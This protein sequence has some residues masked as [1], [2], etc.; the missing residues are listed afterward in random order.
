MY[1][2]KNVKY[3]EYAMH[4]F[5]YGINIVN[6]P[7]IYNYNRVSGVLEMQKIPNMSIADY[8]GE[9]FSAV[10]VHIITKIRE[11]IKILYINGI[12]Y[13]DITGYNFIE[14]GGD[15]WIID[16]EHS[17]Y[18]GKGYTPQDPFVLDFIN[19]REGWNPSFA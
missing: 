12:E 16:F 8:Y 14:W 18:I 9:E 2:K 17:E 1:T 7:A 5:V 11:I 10:P 3:H 6:V 15:I 19:G 13:P 4:R